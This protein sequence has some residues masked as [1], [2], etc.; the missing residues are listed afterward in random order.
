MPVSNGPWRVQCHATPPSCTGSPGASF[1]V[2]NIDR[3][4]LSAVS[5]T[6]AY[7]LPNFSEDH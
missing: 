7:L 4:S 5:G 3:N 1:A 6:P 2:S